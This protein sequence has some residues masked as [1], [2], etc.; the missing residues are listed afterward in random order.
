MNE[1]VVHS[2]HGNIFVDYLNNISTVLFSSLV[3]YF[4][5]LFTALLPPRCLV[6]LP[7]GFATPLQHCWN[8]VSNRRR[9]AI[10]ETLL[11]SVP[12]GVDPLEPGTEWCVENAAQISNGR[13]MTVPRTGKDKIKIMDKIARQHQKNKRRTVTSLDPL[14]LSD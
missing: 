13:P 7:R 12:E 2:K 5:T 11:K 1:P 9:S 4:N 10:N 6:N 8:R 3:L 14:N